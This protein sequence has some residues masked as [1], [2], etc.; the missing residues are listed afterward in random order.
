MSDVLEKT[1]A[2][3]QSKDLP[4]SLQLEL[5]VEDRDTIR[6]LAQYP[7]GQQREDYALEA[8]KI[9]VL[10]LR[11]AA[12]ALDADF[13]QRETN[14]LVET[15]GQ[16]LRNQSSQAH[17]R[18]ASSLQ[19]Y[20]DPEGGRFSQRVKLLT[21]DDGDLS[22]MLRG[23]FDGD[24]SQ[25]AQTLLT[26]FGQS[27]PLM[28]MLDPE[29][30][31][32]LIAI[33]RGNVEQQLTQNRERLLR[34]FS[35]DNPDGALR[36]LVGEI[37]VK[38]GDFTKNMES[39]IDEV[40]KEFSLDEENSALSRLVGNVDSAQKKITQEF[41]LDNKQSALHKLKEELTTI[42][43]AHVKT[44]AEFQEEVKVALGKL[45]TKRETEKKGTQ[46]GFSFEDALFEI[47]FHDAQLRGDIVENTSNSTGLISRC[48]KGDLVLQLGSD[49]IAAGARIV[50]EAK[51]DASYT[52]TRA[53]AELEEARKNRDAQLGVFVFSRRTA[54][55]ELESLARYGSDL[56]VVWDAEDPA[57]DAYLRA[58]LE[59]A[60]ALCLRSQQATRRQ[61][62]D[63]TIVDKAV[64]KIEKA[65]QNL[66]QIRTSAQTIKSSSE[67]ILKRVDLDQQ[68]LDK[69]L[70]L[71]R[72][73]LDDLKQSCR[74][75][76]END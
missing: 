3:A 46:H 12:G 9:G 39:K 10:A 30:S 6:A 42:L 34:E 29:Q 72:E 55:A 24:N 68:A 5:T 37:T 74:S 32:G 15:L 52:L 45:I 40:V 62:A 16:E 44:N 43:S 14:R 49:S 69:Q 36:R 35:L 17:E 75:D 63:F 47:V 25:L 28:K 57:T 73:S 60:R 7:E 41:S 8:L 38:H 76:D 58:A 65:V 18:L 22:R 4:Y 48:L 11:H 61:T 20:F 19:E 13:I 23:M 50:L 59:I 64:L 71:L 67:K 2:R 33:L 56:V 27:S 1:I 31:Q 53:L 21:S 54:P 26:H 66:D 51:Q 70:A